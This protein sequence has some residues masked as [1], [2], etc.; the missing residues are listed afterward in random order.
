MAKFSLAPHM[1]NMM[2]NATNPAAVTPPVRTRS[3]SAGPPHVTASAR[4]GE[5]DPSQA[6]GR[7]KKRDNQLHR[8]R[9]LEVRIQSLQ[10]RVNKLSVPEEAIA[11]EE[12][13]VALTSRS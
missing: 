13:A 4:G 3:G 1:P 2:T 9:V 6:T 5:T 12:A 10:Q 8:A 7:V 11:R